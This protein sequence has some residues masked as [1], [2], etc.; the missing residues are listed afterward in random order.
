MDWSAVTIR[1]LAGGVFVVLF[2]LLG[3]LTTQKRLAGA[4]PVGL[5]SLLFTVVTRGAAH[6]PMLARGMI[7]GAVAFTAYD[8]AM[9]LF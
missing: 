8:V 1:C 4:P 9:F 2:S 7:I 6:L 3:E 5:A